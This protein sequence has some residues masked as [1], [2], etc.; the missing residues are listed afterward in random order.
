MTASP[1]MLIV[2]SGP[3]RGELEAPPSK[4]SSHRALLL[5]A[6][7]R[8]T[9]RL[10][11]C[12]DAEDVALTRD[13]LA[14]LGVVIVPDGPGALLV[15]GCGGRLPGL[16]V[17]LHLGNAGT[18]LR[19]LTAVAAL[20]PG[21]TRL[22]GVPRLRQRPIGGLA[23]ALEPLGARVEWEAE[24]GFAPLVVNG[25]PLPGGSTRLGMG[26]SSQ[27]ASAL[28]L[29][30]PCTPRGV[31][32]ALEGTAVSRPYL[33]LTLDW[34]ER[35]GGPPIARSAGRLAIPGGQGYRAT[36]VE[37]EGDY[38]TAAFFLAGAAV[39]GG[40]VRVSGL[41]SRSRQ[42]DVA[43]LPFLAAMGCVVERDAESVSVAGPRRLRG[44]DA[45]ISD[46]PDLAPVIAAVAL[47]A[48]GPTA[49]RGA[50]HLRL[51]ESDRIGDLAAGLRLLGARVEER[52]DGLTL[53]PGA[54]RP[55][56]LDPRGDHRLAMAFA[57]AGLRI[58]GVELLDPD[59]VAKSCPDFFSRID[60]LRT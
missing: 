42:A 13:A 1:W 15:H 16:T 35:F 38:S 22:D 36:D 6:L 20:G 10:S 37:I 30:S 43:F 26:E 33:D 2:P 11:R 55:A 25:G 56:R 47:F 60:Q 52:S 4:S 19:F 17:D 49:L 59:C 45:E 40:R 12:L 14:R 31:E 39:T 50:P 41:P 7:A 48:E 46:C 8:G 57:I 28:L 24:P 18:G 9:S 5:A 3:L 21:R 32:I 27:F 23:R 54:P 53:H 44:I 58:D 51:K 29:V 34:M